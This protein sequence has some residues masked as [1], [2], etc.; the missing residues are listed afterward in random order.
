MKN[1]P[2]WQRPIAWAIIVLATPF[3]CAWCVYRSAK[4]RIWAG[5]IFLNRG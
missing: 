1:L 5:K 2:A 4:R 3:V